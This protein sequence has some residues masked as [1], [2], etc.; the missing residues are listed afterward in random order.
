[1]A[2]APG[3]LMEIESSGAAGEVEDVPAGG[4]QSASGGGS[5]EPGG[6]WVLDNRYYFLWDG[7]NLSMELDGDMNALRSYGWGLDLSRSEQGA[8]GVGGLLFATHHTGASAGTYHTTYDG[9]GNLVSLRS[10]AGLAMARYEYGPF[11]ETVTSRDVLAGVNPFRFSTK[12]QDAET[13]LLYYGYRYYSAGMGRWLSRD[14]IEEGGGF[15]L[16]ALVGNDSVNEL[17]YLGLEEIDLH[18]GWPLY[19]GGDPSQLCI[20]LDSDKHPDVH[21]SLS[22][23]IEEKYAKRH[24]VVRGMWEKKYDYHRRVWIKM[25]DDER[26][27]AI[28]R[29]LLA[30]GVTKKG[31]D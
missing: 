10:S 15:N 17:D 30:G 9:N 19:L 29:S 8:G 7:W 18:H 1:M 6:I 28:R 20:P 21:K 3:S 14:P 26:Y 16:F 2:L 12:Y 25:S 5:T 31:H 22:E 23:L 11:G 4:A 27:S 24:R 13:G